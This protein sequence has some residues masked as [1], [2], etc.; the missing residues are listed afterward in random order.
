MSRDLK[1]YTIKGL[2]MFYESLL[3]EGKIKKGGY[4]YTRLQY[5]KQIDKRRRYYQ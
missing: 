5:F 1:H 2:V 4:A 3:E